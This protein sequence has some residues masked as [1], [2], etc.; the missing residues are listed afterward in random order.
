MKFR[1]VAFHFV[2]SRDLI[3]ASGIGSGAEVADSVNVEELADR[4]FGGLVTL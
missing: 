2:R 3:S 1:R 4:C